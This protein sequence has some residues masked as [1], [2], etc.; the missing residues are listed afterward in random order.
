M[1]EGTHVDVWEIRALRQ[2]LGRLRLGHF[3]ASKIK[4]VLEGPSMGQRL[5]DPRFTADPSL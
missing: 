2:E 5:L 3:W 1:E 4:A